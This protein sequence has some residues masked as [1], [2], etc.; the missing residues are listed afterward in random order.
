MM[1]RPFSAALALAVAMPLAGCISLGP[2]APPY[3]LNLTA[4]EAP[5]A[6]AARTAGPGEAITLYVPTVP[7]ELQTTRVP[8]RSGANAIS[9]LKDAQW[10]E[11][12]A[13]LFQQLLAATTDRRTGRLVLNPRQA[14]LDPGQRILGDLERFGIDASPAQAVVVFEAMRQNRD[15]TRI[16]QR[17]FEARVPIAA[18]E[19]AAAGAGLNTAANQVAAQ[20]ADWIGAAPAGR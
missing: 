6:G 1:L 3:F 20:V 5:A 17:R 8:V 4:A 7:Q 16:E 10:V 18:V 9:Y 2:K 15:G 13:R 11:S 14:S 12:P 19:P